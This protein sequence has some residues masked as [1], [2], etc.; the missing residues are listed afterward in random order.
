[1]TKPLALVGYLG[2]NNTITVASSL[3]ATEIAT[4]ACL[5]KENGY[6]VALCKTDETV[7][8]GT[9]PKTGIEI[10]DNETQPDV[11]W[12]HQAC[13]NLPGGVGP[14]HLK[15]AD[16][17]AK[18]MPGAKKIYRLLVDNSYSMSHK[19]LLNTLGAKAKSASYVKNYA[20]K[21]PN[22]SYQAIYDA[23][24]AAVERESF[25][26]V[27]YETMRDLGAELPFINIDI[28]IRQL[29]LCL[30]I[31]PREEKDLDFCYIGSSRS[32][33][34]KKQAR[35]DSIGD[36]VTHENS[37]FGG[38]LFSTA[39]RFPKAWS[40]MSRSKAHVVTRDRSM[41][42]APLHRYMQALIHDAVPVVVN[43]PEPVA[44]IH[45]PD[46][47]DRLRVKSLAEAVELVKERD[48]LLPLLRK[49]REY[50]RDYVRSKQGKL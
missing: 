9:N 26:E 2:P 40:M 16:A 6:D 3:V 19:Q 44:F 20:P 42:Q 17:L 18:A 38:S 47:Q 11:V 22:A 46:L 41:I 23:V 39:V 45:S 37:F 24:T 4:M 28:S 35:I 29:E 30:D 15:S 1:M 36:I 10:W 5:L 31:F 7:K 43:E 48:S 34:K 32:D 25:Y 12:L 14:I 13:V 33:K 21:G 50:W 27:G 8:T 49:E